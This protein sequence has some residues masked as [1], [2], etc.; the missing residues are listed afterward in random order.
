MLVLFRALILRGCRVCHR[1]AMPDTLLPEKRL[2]SALFTLMLLLS[3]LLLPT[4][5]R[6]A[7]SAEEANAAAAADT[8]GGAEVEFPI[9]P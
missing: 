1:L 8:V 7:E 6:G 3:A 9:A 2:S 4:M 5:P